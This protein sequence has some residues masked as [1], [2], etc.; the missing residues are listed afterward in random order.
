M[1]NTPSPSLIAFAG[2]LALLSN[3]AFALDYQDV[4]NAYN[5]I[6]FW[7]VGDTGVSNAVD[8]AGGNDGIYYYDARLSQGGPG[9]AGP[10]DANQNASAPANS[11]TQGALDTWSGTGGFVAINNDS[12]YQLNEGTFSIWFKDDGHIGNNAGLFSKDRSG[13]GTGGHITASTQSDGN[14][15]GHVQVRLQN[16]NQ[17]FYVNS[18]S[19]SFELDEW[20]HAAF[21]FGADG[22]KLYINGQLED[23]NSYTGGITGNYEPIALGGTRMWSNSSSLSNVS[24]NYSGFLDDFAIFDVALDA[25]AI[26]DLYTGTVP[27]GGG[28]GVPLPGTAWLMLIG[29]A[30]VQRRKFIK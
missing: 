19:S 9:H 20:V 10:F 8:T 26:D 17:S 14:N 29:A 27:G 4:V 3:A 22:M 18:S 13:Y 15:T 23:T 28:G 2:G 5:P 11:P 1:K 24:R 21:T 7:K 25:D 16:T 6:G 30:W 12:D